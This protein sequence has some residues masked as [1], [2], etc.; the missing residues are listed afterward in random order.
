MAVRGDLLYAINRDG[1]SVDSYDITETHPQKQPICDRA[2]REQI[3]NPFDLAYD[4][5]ANQLLVLDGAFHPSLPTYIFSIKTITLPNKEEVK[6]NSE[7]DLTRMLQ[8]YSNWFAS[9]NR[10]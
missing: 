8:L 6:D 3:V 4:A 5:K 2:C 1:R 9:F 10:D 7:Q